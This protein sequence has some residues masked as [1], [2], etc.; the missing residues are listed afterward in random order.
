L[1]KFK[2]KKLMVTIVSSLVVVVAILLM[3]DA[4]SE[5]GVNIPPPQLTLYK[6][7]D[8]TELSD[9]DDP[10]PIGSVACWLNAELKIKDSLGLIRGIEKS[11]FL[12]TNPTHVLVTNAL[13][14]DESNIDIQKEGSSYV[15]VPSI[16]C[17]ANEVMY[18]ASSNSFQLGESLDPN[19]PESQ[20]FSNLI[21]MPLTIEQPLVIYDND[22]VARIYAH[23]P[24]GTIGD[25]FN[26]KI[27]VQRKELISTTSTELGQ[28]T[29]D[30][31]WTV[32]YLREGTYSSEHKFAVE[33][34]VLMGY[35]ET[36][37]CK[38][39]CSAIRFLVPIDTVQTYNK[40]GKL[41][42][43]V[44]PLM[45]YRTINVQTGEGDGVVD[46][47]EDNNDKEE[48]CPTGYNKVGTECV[49]AGGGIDPNKPPTTLPPEEDF[50]TAL[51]TCLNSGDKTCLANGKF[52][53]L[54]IFGLGFILLIGALV[55]KGS[56]R[57][58]IYGV[59]TY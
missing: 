17:N 13:I 43:V 32:N 1:G 25:V 4:D 47:P 42:S 50:F 7:D 53:P 52:L 12:K 48:I 55:Q 15:L 49:K 23:Y 57:P 33:G 22:L 2:P 5:F 14:D 8:G 26:G 30:P 11:S 40:D 21:G 44:N 59:P 3:A 35:K 10:R 34:F 56:G 27:D 19:K 20:L 18:E 37:T 24:D 41:T 28:I 29:I 46:V 51:K 38:G 58:D 39:S 9:F 36:E 31:L 6:A 16:K 54:W 45:T